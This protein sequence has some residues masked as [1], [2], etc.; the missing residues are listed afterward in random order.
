MDRSKARATNF[1]SVLRC[2]CARQFGGVE[3]LTNVSRALGVTECQR[4]RRLVHTDVRRPGLG[5]VVV[6]VLPTPLGRL[7]REIEVALCPL[8]VVA[9]TRDGRQ[10]AVQRTAQGHHDGIGGIEAFRR[11]LGVLREAQ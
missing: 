7:M 8:S 6:A 10:L 9:A 5:A 1:A 2:A 3:C 4:D 11:V